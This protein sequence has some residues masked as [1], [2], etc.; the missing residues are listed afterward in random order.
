MHFLFSLALDEDK[1]PDAECT[2]TMSEEVASLEKTKQETMLV[3]D[4]GEDLPKVKGNDEEI[5]EEKVEAESVPTEAETEPVK[6][7]EGEEVT[8][9]EEQLAESATKNVMAE[10]TEKEDRSV[11]IT[12]VHFIVLN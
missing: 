10:A 3:Q 5:K 6:D 2:P 4:N 8:G 1:R 12:S 7:A 11:K 9:K